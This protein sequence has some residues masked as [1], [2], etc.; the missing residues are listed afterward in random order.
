MEDEGGRGRLTFVPE[1]VLSRCEM[2]IDS[3]SMFIQNHC[4]EHYGSVYDLAEALSFFSD[5]DLLM[6]RV[7]S[8]KFVSLC[9]Y[10]CVL[11]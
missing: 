5:S 7:Y 6:A 3:L 2:E 10:V 4:I 11:T 9:W 8:T 1:E